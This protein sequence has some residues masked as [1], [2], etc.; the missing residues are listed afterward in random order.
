VLPRVRYG[1][2]YLLIRDVVGSVSGSVGQEGYQDCLRATRY[3]RGHGLAIT[4]DSIILNE[5]K[6]NP[7][8]SSP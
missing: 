8:Y 1:M 2:T 7:P 3:K 6:S 4:K 5:P